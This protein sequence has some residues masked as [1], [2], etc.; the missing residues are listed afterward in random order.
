MHGLKVQE[1]A[2]RCGAEVHGPDNLVSGIAHA[3][4]RKLDPGDLF[5]ALPGA[6]VD[7]HD[8]LNQAAAAGA[9]AALISV[10]PPANQLKQL[11]ELSLLLV[12]NSLHAL[13]Q[14]ARCH[15]ADLQCELI[16]I[17]GAVGKTSAKDVLAL[18]LG[19][20]AEAVHAA[21]ASFNSEIGLPLAVLAAAPSS[22]RMVLEYGVNEPGEMDVLL[23]IAQPDHVWLTALSDAHLEGMGSLSTIVKEKSK[24]CAA[25]KATVWSTRETAGVAAANGQ[26]WGLG[27][28]LCGFDQHQRHLCTSVPGN[29]TLDL[30][31]CGVVKLALLARHQAETV[32]VAVALAAHLG[33]SPEQLRK[34]LS[35]VRGPAGRME[36]Q[37]FDQ[38]QV[39]DDS[40]NASPCSMRAALTC[41]RDWPC[42]A[43]RVA[44]LGTMH[45][46][47]AQSPHFHAELG[48]YAADCKLDLMIG[49]GPGGKQI[50]DAADNVGAACNFKYFDR[51]EE[52]DAAILSQLLEPD[53]VVLLKASRA[54]QLE[55]LLP[56]LDGLF[57]RTEVMS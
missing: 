7:G 32:A 3:D 21:P 11:A 29:F 38:L 13:Q 43:T 23:S 56:S 46:L 5:V 15:L 41:L 2:A 53:C 55:K 20:E 42:P 45:E 17:T 4:S 44:I 52:L 37:C 48:F 51:V 22:K 35:E 6:R 36:L 49:I 9:S 25:A 34:R 27:A 1:L 33:V 47:G 16:G 8:Y 54:E 10:M 28:N 50:L 57:C 40:Y 19:G 26:M 31:E 30:P 24:L 18:L 14:L 39:I 12:E